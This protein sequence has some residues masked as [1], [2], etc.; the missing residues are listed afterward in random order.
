MQIVYIADDLNL[1]VFSEHNI[2]RKPPKDLRPQFGV[3]STSP[4]V[5]GGAIVLKVRF[6]DYLSFAD[7]TYILEAQLCRSVALLI[8][9]RL[10][11]T[12]RDE[13]D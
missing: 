1:A 6:L 5:T 9:H 2:A 3:A 11:E 8:Q 7:V 10:K 12:V 4:A 13:R